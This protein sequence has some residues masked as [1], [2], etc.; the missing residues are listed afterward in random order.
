M[1]GNSSSVPGRREFKNQPTRSRAGSVFAAVRR[2]P[3]HPP[4]RGAPATG[5]VVFDEPIDAPRAV[6]AGTGATSGESRP[7]ARPGVHCTAQRGIGGFGALVI[8]LVFGPF[9]MFIAACLGVARRVDSPS[10]FTGR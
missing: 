2:H 4:R 5:P 6:S 9:M 7:R 3:S 1:L 10:S 8:G